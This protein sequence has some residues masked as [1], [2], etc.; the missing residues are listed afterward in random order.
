MMN[1]L[2]KWGNF[3]MQVY[4]PFVDLKKFHLEARDGKIGG[5]FELRVYKHYS[6]GTGK[7]REDG[8]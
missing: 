7:P 5:D 4:R 3:G 1:N 2:N 8:Q 6:T